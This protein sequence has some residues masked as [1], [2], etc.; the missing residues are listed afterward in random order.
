[1][2]TLATIVNY[3]TGLHTFVEPC[4]ENDNIPAMELDHSTTYH[5]GDRFMY[6]GVL[7]HVIG[8]K[9]VPKNADSGSI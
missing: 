8:E 9:T 6:E 1:M 5:V 2:S 3:G 4:D 7:Y